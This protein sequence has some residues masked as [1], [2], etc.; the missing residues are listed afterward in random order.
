MDPVRLPLLY[1]VQTSDPLL[2]VLE[3]LES[4]H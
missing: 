4:R 2:D 1:Q 3:T